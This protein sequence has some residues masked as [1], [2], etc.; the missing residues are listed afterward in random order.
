MEKYKTKLLI[1]RKQKYTM[2]IRHSNSGPEI[3]ISN[4]EYGYVATAHIEQ[5]GT[6]RY[7]FT[8]HILHKKYLHQGLGT[9]LMKELA[10]ECRK[11]RIKYIYGII[12]P[13]K[14]VDYE[15]PFLFYKN[16]KS[17]IFHIKDFAFITLET[18]NTIIDNI[19]TN[20]LKCIFKNK[21]YKD[22]NGSQQFEKSVVLYQM[23]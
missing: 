2:H 23:R 14:M 7:E 10:K 19:N 16:L 12:A 11:Q 21:K 18:F 15:I 8:I 9:I 17:K 3:S 5:V 22:F 1:H 20:E 13:S 4:D 6:V